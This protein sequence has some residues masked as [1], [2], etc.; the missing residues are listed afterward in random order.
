MRENI[1]EWN[2]TGNVLAYP[3]LESYFRKDSGK[4]RIEIRKSKV[5]L[6]AD[7]AAWPSVRQEET[8]HTGCLW[9]SLGPS[10]KWGH[11][12]NV[13]LKSGKTGTRTDRLRASRIL[14]E[15]LSVRGSHVAQSQCPALCGLYLQ[16]S[17]QLLFLKTRERSFMFWKG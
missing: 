13:A 14:L 10:G 6:W 1:S 16:D 17:C 9:L 2:N 4:G 11:S 8:E 5:W 15:R 7:L 3:F 12:E